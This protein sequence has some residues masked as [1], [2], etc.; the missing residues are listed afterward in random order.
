MGRVLIS[1]FAIILIF[2]GLVGIAIGGRWL[3]RK[4][5]GAS[6]E[7]EARQAAQRTR[8]R[9]L[10]PRWEELEHHFQR[11]I[12]K[13]IKDLY[14]NREL[15]TLRDVALVRRDGH[16]WRISELLPADLLTISEIPPGLRSRD[17]FPIAVNQSRD[18]FYISLSEGSYPVKMFRRLDS[19]SE[20]VATSVLDFI[21]GLD[22]P[23]RT[24]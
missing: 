13:I 3:L 19:G 9:L 2:V 10:S 24:Y 12:P 22:R 20:L 16:E 14:A 15:I 18:V 11:P 17:A 1:L 21:A 6:P 7:E 5:L 4:L 8:T 23:Q